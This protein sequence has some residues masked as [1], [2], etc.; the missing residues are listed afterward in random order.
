MKYK[1]CSVSSSD[2]LRR[3]FD[4]V[5]ANGYSGKSVIG[6]STGLT[7]LDE[8][9]WGMDPGQLIV[10]AGR[11]SMGKTSLAMNIAAHVACVEGEH[12]AVFNMEINSD[13]VMIRALSSLSQTNARRICSEIARIGDD[14]QRFF[15]AVKE[16][17][18]APLLIA[19]LSKNTV[20]NIRAEIVRLKRNKNVRLIVVDCLQRMLKTDKQE[21]AATIVSGLKS[22]AMDLQI[23]VILTSQLNK[24]IDYRADK[25]PNVSDIINIG[26]IIDDADLILLLY[27]H[28]VYYRDEVFWQ[29]PGKDNLS[30]VA[31]IIVGKNRNGPLRNFRVWFFVE[32]ARFIDKLEE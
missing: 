30:G 14:R 19:T 21:E 2:L 9:T 11:P 16:L 32:H 5:E 4:R 23:T 27:R 29:K 8:I 22:L 13:N 1:A 7:L 20:S 31:E 26:N 18:E 17:V 6:L 25:R 15:S 3:F 12:V 28:E 10:I 24:T